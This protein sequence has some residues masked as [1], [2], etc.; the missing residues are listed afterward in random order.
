MP[1][2]TD[3]PCLFAYIPDSLSQVLLPVC[4]R[5]RYQDILFHVVVSLC[6]V[7]SSTLTFSVHCFAACKSQVTVC[8]CVCFRTPADPFASFGKQETS[9]ALGSFLEKNL[10]WHNQRAKQLWLEK[11]QNYGFCFGNEPLH[12]THWEEVMLVG[13]LGKSNPPL[14][15]LRHKKCV[16]SLKWS[17]KN[18]GL[19]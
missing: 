17:Y 6:P 11:E 13:N 10:K 19:S 4:R 9:Q 12:F 3:L 5:K 1:Q 8:V 2:E 15:L 16:S 14:T 7:L 18:K